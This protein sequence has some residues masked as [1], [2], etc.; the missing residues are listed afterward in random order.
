MHSNAVRPEL[1]EVPVNLI[2]EPALP[3]RSS[4]DD[5]KLAELVATMRAVGFTSTIA[6]VRRGDRY[7]VIAG[8]RR[9][10]AAGRAGIV[11][12]PC[13]VFP[14][15]TT[16]LKA[17]QHGENKYHEDLSP[18]D[19]AI[20]FAQLF[21]EDPGGGTDAVAAAVGESRD[22][23][24]GRINLLAGD[25]A[26]FTALAEGKIGVGVA[27][28]LNRVTQQEFRRSFLDQAVHSEATVATVSGWVA[29]WKTRLEPATRDVFTGAEQ[30]AA[31][32]PIA[33]SYFTCHAC[34]GTEHPSHM[35]PIQIHDYCLQAIV[36]PA[37]ERWKRQNDFVAWPRS[38]DEARDLVNEIADRFPALLTER[39][40]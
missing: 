31:A 4:M 24:E 32:R 19:E 2:D 33:N 15:G 20:W 27:Q 34:G 25:G 1:L 12:V 29:E 11:A 28:Q 22:Y 39:A 14:P 13:L 38:V 21:D 7:E 26:V 5:T 10:I 23:V 17:I 8:H 16:Q 37:L 35:L 18:A 36:T 9:R 3:S 40:S 30:P 6:V